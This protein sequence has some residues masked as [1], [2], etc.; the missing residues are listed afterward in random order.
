MSLTHKTPVLYVLDY[1]IYQR[2]INDEKWRMS[3]SS[4]F[5][6]NKKSAL[7]VDFFLYLSTYLLS[8]IFC[9]NMK[10]QTLYIVISII[11]L[12]LFS[13]AIYYAQAAT[14]TLSL[15]IIWFGIRH[16]TPNNQQLWNISSSPSD[17]DLNTQFTEP[18]RV[19]D[20]EWY[21]TGH[22]T[23]IQCNGVYGPANHRLTWVELKAG[24]NT[25]E[26]LMWLTGNY[27]KINTLLTDYTNIIEPVTYIYKETDLSNIWKVNKYGDK[28]RLKILIPSAT[29][30]GVYSGTIVFSFYME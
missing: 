21:A 2:I 9:Y 6:V 19:E 29:P 28:P 4:I 22:Y 1:I 24:N 5:L 18:F 20:I 26:L 10:K 23:T 3:G 25:P 17:Q 11:T 14:W 30:P 8:L 12:F 16:G 27:V 7:V 13:W 15:Q